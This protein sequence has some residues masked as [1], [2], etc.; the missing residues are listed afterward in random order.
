MNIIENASIKKRLFLIF[1]VP[2]V[3]IILLS[4][5]VIFEHYQ[6]YK[7]YQKLEIMMNLNSNI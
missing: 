7:H 2:L 5:L 6:D 1:I 4:S 3:A